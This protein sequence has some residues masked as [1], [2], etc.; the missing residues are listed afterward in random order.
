MKIYILTDQEG[1][2]GVVNSVDYASPAG[3]FVVG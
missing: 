1:V 3:F 2:A